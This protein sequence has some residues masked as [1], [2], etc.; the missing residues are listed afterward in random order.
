M[1]GIENQ[2]AESWSQTL[3]TVL[4][5]NSDHISLYPLTIEKHTPFYDQ[6]KKVDYDLQA[7]MY[8]IACEKLKDAGFTHYEISNWA[9]DGK[10][11]IDSTRCL[12]ACGI[13]PVFTV[14]GEVYG[15][16]TVKKLD[17]VLDELITK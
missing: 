12:G 3:D 17:E 7:I 11:S 2:T 4:K 5:L 9:K 15:K 16:A 13:A 1:Y 6:N 10:F 14:N 8:N